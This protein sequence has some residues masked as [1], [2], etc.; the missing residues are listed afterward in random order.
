MA[1]HLLLLKSLPSLLSPVSRPFNTLILNCNGL[2]YFLHV[3]SL[4]LFPLR[5]LSLSIILNTVQDVF[6][7][8]RALYNIYV[9]ICFIDFFLSLSAQQL[10]LTARELVCL[11]YTVG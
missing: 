7:N 5:S 10:L 6:I 3:V 8:D 4:H 1:I 9:Y 2:S 11:L